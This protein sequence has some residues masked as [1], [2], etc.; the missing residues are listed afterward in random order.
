M[1]ADLLSAPGPGGASAAAPAARL[2]GGTVQE[3]VGS[4]A[5]REVAFTGRVA[6]P[7]R[8]AGGGC[9]TDSPLRRRHVRASGREP[10]AAGGACGRRRGRTAPNGVAGGRREHPPAL[11]LSRA[12]KSR[13]W[14]SPRRRRGRFDTLLI[15]STSNWS[16]LTHPF[17]KTSFTTWQNG[18]GF[19][20]ANGYVRPRRADGLSALSVWK[21]V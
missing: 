8:T 21:R 3:A 15:E 14:A 13:V 6:R 4:K 1:R 18:G 16:N 10:C 17:Y 19:C 9:V 2:P 20:P 7:V 5:M 12:A 11:S